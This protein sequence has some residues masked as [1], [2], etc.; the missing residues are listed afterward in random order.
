VDAIRSDAPRRQAG[1]QIAHE[2]RRATDKE[3]AIARQIKRLERT[4]I[5]PPRRIEVDVRTILLGGRAVANVAMLPGKRCQQRARAPRIAKTL[6]AFAQLV[7]VREKTGGDPT[8]IVPCRAPHP[9]PA[10]GRWAT[11]SSIRK[12]SIWIER[13]L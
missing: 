4:H 7:E 5:Q 2:R 8:V 11:G 3:I 6:D 13:I 10:G 12:S 9:Q 1:S